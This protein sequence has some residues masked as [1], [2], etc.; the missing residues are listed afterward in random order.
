MAQTLLNYR[1]KATDADG[2][3]VKGVEKAAS[4]RAS[5]CEHCARNSKKSIPHSSAYIAT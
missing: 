2:A 5:S 4:V 3:N 1:Y